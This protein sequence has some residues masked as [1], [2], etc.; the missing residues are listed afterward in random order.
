M[1]EQILICDR[2]KFPSDGNIVITDTSVYNITS[3]NNNVLLG[4][5]SGIS[6]K[7]GRYNILI[8]SNSGN[9]VTTGS[10]NT[11]IGSNSGVDSSTRSGCVVIGD[12]L[13]TVAADNTCHI[14]GISGVTTATADAVAVLVS[15]DN[16]LGV[17][18]SSQRYKENITNL[19]ITVENI[20]QLNPK[21]FSWKENGNRDFGMIA[22]EAYTV[23][24]EI[25]VKNKEGDIETIQY[26]KLP[27]LNLQVIKH[28]EER[29]RQLESQLV[30]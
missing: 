10:T 13:T 2:I 20:L 27:V 25:V 23:V 28:L 30:G 3:G 11:I 1:S 14:K 17:T 7:E 12:G 8:G 16:Q 24:P 15:S 18:S 9:T 21:S 5:D 6:L 29:I 4:S 26:H 22:E 19:E